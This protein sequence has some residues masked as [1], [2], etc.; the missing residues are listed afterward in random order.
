MK[1]FTLLLI[2]NLFLFVAFLLPSPCE[3][4]AGNWTW[5]SGSNSPGA[6]AVYGP[7]GLNPTMIKLG[8]RHGGSMWKDAS[9]NLWFFGGADYGGNLYNDLWMYNPANARWS[10]ITGDSTGFSP[11]NNSQ[12]TAGI[13]GARYAQSSWTDAAG[14]FWIFGGYGV[15][16]TGQLGLLNDVWEF[17]FAKQ[18]WTWITGSQQANN[19]GVYG[20]QGQPDTGNMPGGR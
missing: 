7:K 11:V 9:G 8:N 3:V 17:N 18:E 20:T 1:N 4:Q 5:V 13:P 16:G 6:A 2:F 12:G 15:D 10:W 19:G 14:N